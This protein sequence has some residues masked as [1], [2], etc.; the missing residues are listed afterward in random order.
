MIH[1]IVLSSFFLQDYISFIFP[2]VFFFLV[3]F[4]GVV[5]FLFISSLLCVLFIFFVFH[6]HVLAPA[7]VFCWP[8]IVDPILRRT[9]MR[10][11]VAERIF[12]ISLVFSADFFS[13]WECLDID[14][15]ARCC[16]TFW[17]SLLSLGH[18]WIIQL[19]PLARP[20]GSSASTGLLVQ[21]EDEK[22]RQG[23][24]WEGKVLRVFSSGRWVPRNQGWLNFWETRLVTVRKSL[25]RSCWTELTCQGILLP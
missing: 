6:L 4:F 1:F 7:N 20:L 21:E 2:L 12:Y 5:V 14:G 15:F 23:R 9:G 22:E 16:L 3:F 17:S 25:H 13:L 8:S 11:Q 24:T 10:F 18:S 19:L